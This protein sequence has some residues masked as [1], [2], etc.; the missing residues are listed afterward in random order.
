MHPIYL[1]EK[2]CFVT[3]NFNLAADTIECVRSL[4]A[5]GASLEQIIVVDNASTDHSPDHLRAA[6]GDELTIVVSEINRGYAHGIN[7]GVDSGMRS[8]FAWF[9][10]MNNDI[11]VAPDFLSVLACAAKDTH[12]LFGPAIFYYDQPS[13][14]WSMGD[15]RVRGT[16]FGYSLFR[17]RPLKPNLPAVMPV[18][19]LNGCCMLIHRD[20]FEH[21]GY[22]DTSY[23]MYVE[24]VDFCWRAYQA[25]FRMATVPAAHMFHKVSFSARRM[26]SS[27][28]YLRVRNQNWFYRHYSSSFQKLIMAPL[29]LLRNLIFSFR[30]IVRG[31]GRSALTVL[32]GWYDGWFRMKG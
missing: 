28:L 4:Q 20:V 7:L 16:L 22:W 19:F 13:I 25:G 26:G 27:A 12:T 18:D 10:L 29:S 14:V 21:I 5:A 3:V 11:T 9:L 6:L 32:A 24:E 8:G 15:Y 17:N 1:L 31:E 23:Y 2:W 30:Q